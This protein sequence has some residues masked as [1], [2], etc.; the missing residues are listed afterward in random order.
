MICPVLASN[1]FHYA[2]SYNSIECVTLF[3]YIYVA[4][5]K[6][7]VHKNTPTRYKS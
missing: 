5:K 3:S 6:N 7:Q 1:V 4:I 2:K